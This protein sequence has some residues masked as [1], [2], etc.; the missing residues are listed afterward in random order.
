ME[1]KEGKEGGKKEGQER[2]KEK[3]RKR[4]KKKKSEKGKRAEKERKEGG[5]N[6]KKKEG[7][8]W[9]YGCRGAPLHS[10]R[11]LNMWYIIDWGWWTW[12]MVRERSAL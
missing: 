6:M 2:K 5:E 11:C 12:C 4:T 9:V 1:V 7:G 3:K 10:Y 8:G